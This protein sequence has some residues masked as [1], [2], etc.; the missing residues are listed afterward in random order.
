[1]A[2]QTI[3]KAEVGAEF[4]DKHSRDGYGWPLD[5]WHMLFEAKGMLG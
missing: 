4:R 3:P 2:E 1:V 5:R